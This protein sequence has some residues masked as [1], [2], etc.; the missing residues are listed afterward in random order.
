MAFRVSKRRSLWLFVLPSLITSAVL[1]GIPV[2]MVLWLSLTDA[3]L[4]GQPAHFVGL[5]NYLALAGDDRLLGACGNTVLIAVS[6]AIM[7]TGL[8][9]AL[10]LALDALRR[11][12]QT[13][14]AL[15]MLPNIITPVAGALFLK[16]IFI[17]RWGLA[18][19][20]LIPMG[21]DPPDWL[22]DPSWARGI[23]VF[24]DTWR[25]MP[26][27]ALVIYAA[28]QMLDRALIDAA[29]V[30]GA[31]GWQ[32]LRHV[33]LPGLRPVLLVIFGLRLMDGIRLFDLVYMLTDGGPGSATETISLYAYTLAMR[34]LQLGQAAAVGVIAA[35]LAVAPFL[36]ALPAR[37]R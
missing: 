12:A 9:L 18:D 17:T 28:L 34:R 2:A 24:G 10:A 36:A 8:G 7:Q 5:A 13:L 3:A 25:A 35:L 21:I 11:G 19:A 32:V 37:R 31:T 23:V 27:A 14:L 6:G 22:G 20:V 26:F 16:W 1:F 29:R 33:V 30:D 4:Q 15:I